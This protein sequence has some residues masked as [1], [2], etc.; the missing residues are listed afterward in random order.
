MC[1]SGRDGDGDA[2]EVVV[3]DI[4]GT[5]IRVNSVRPGEDVDPSRMLVEDTCAIRN[6]RC[7]D[8]L[9]SI[10]KRYAEERRVSPAAVVIGMPVSFDAGMNVVL[11][12]N[13]VPQLVGL[14][15]RDA[16]VRRLGIPVTLEHDAMLLL[17]GEARV[18]GTPPGETV[19]GVFFGTGIGGAVLLG[20]RPFRLPGM[21]FELG[22]IPVGVAGRRCVCGRTDCVEAYANGHLLN[23][24]AE[25]TRT[26]ISE[27]FGLWG[28]GEVG[29][30]L[31]RI[32]EYQSIAVAT[33]VT[34]FGP[35]RAVIGGGVCGM[36][37][38]PREA[39][40]A[41]VRARLQRP[42]PADDLRIDWARLGDRAAYYGALR[43]LDD[44]GARG[45]RMPVE[46]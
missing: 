44:V 32:V 6:G 7:L 19:L 26:P 43:V 29:E 37:G 35:S 16:L 20:G 40:E 36:A 28:R 12:C 11:K 1:S 10:V 34:L 31:E 38:Y 4:G 15:V 33:G 41:Q 14:P 18:L 22:H 17:L 24:L 42:R 5:R 25:R 46:M 9:C 39:L 8:S 2:G 23:D 27:L 3:V 30:E 45:G 21:G 13:N